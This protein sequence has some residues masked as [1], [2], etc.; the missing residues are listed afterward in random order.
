MGFGSMEHEPAQRYAPLRD[1]SREDY[2]TSVLTCTEQDA[3]GTDPSASSQVRENYMAVHVAAGL[4]IVAFIDSK[5]FR[6][7]MPPHFTPCCSA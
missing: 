3:S 6:P 1:N 2:P 7:A 4:K 5:R